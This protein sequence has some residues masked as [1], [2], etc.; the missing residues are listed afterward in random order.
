M[1]REEDSEEEDEKTGGRGGDHG[2]QDSGSF[3]FFVQPDGN[4]LKV[5]RKVFFVSFF[6]SQSEIK[7]KVRV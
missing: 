3:G 7:Q 1:K 6:K 4:P 2:K 5:H